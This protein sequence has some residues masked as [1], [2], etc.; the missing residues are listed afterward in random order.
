M[1][2]SN[3]NGYHLTIDQQNTIARV[4]KALLDAECY[5]EASEVDNTMECFGDFL[6]LH[7]YVSQALFKTHAIMH[8]H[9]MTE[10]AEKLANELENHLG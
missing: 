10:G 9:N 2:K 3:N 1:A 4:G 8:I 5:L 6:R 7:K